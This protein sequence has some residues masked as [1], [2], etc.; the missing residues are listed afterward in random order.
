MVMGR[1]KLEPTQIKSFKL[2]IR[3]WNLLKKASEDEQLS[4]NGLIWRLVENHLVE[5]GLMSDKDRKHPP[6]D[7]R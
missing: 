2:P 1:R 4:L 5:R 7:G 6:L 3:L